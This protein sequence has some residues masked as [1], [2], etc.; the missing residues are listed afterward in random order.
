MVL[1]GLTSSVWWLSVDARCLLATF[2]YVISS[3]CR[4]F[5]M[6]VSA[7]VSVDVLWLLDDRFW[8]SLDPVLVRPV[9]KMP[10]F[11]GFG[12]TGG[13]TRTFCCWF[14][15]NFIQ[16]K[17]DNSLLEIVVYLFYGQKMILL[18]MEEFPFLSRCTQWREEKVRY[19]KRQQVYWTVLLLLING[20]IHRDGCS[21]QN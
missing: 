8:E 4:V 1:N 16:W 6:R 19:L 9:F 12:G 11:G 13:K 20:L 21:K 10:R 2:S 14:V 15:T 18:W 17:W 3:F 5:L 7:V